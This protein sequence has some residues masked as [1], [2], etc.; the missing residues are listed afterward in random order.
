MFTS[1]L[2][3]ISAEMEV[4]LSI[5]LLAVM[6]GMYIN[7]IQIRWCGQYGVLWIWGNNIDKANA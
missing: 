7:N 2:Q 1:L 4:H 6:A 3:N 5:L